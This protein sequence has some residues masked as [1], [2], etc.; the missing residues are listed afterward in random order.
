MPA[1]NESI[2][3]QHE[4]HHRDCN[5]H[6]SCLHH[7]STGNS[8]VAVRS[9]P[10]TS[11]SN[12]GNASRDSVVTF[13]DV[14]VR[15]Y[16]RSLG[17]WW[18]VEYGLSL[19]WDYTEIPAKPL[20]LDEDDANES[21]AK[22]KKNAKKAKAKVKGWFL[23][24]RNRRNSLGTI[25]PKDLEEIVQ[26]SDKARVRSRSKKKDWIKEKEKP[27][28]KRLYE[29]YKPTPKNRQELLQEFGFTEEEMN[30]AESERKLL[31]FEYSQWTCDSKNHS[32]LFL[33]RCLAF[34]NSPS[35]G[36]LPNA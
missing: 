5:N 2:S 3:K 13:G 19:G 34:T 24:N 10:E 28:V 6:K 31:R 8:S 21:V 29:D 11:A 9:R 26:I 33:Q 23:V 1:D 20:P 15:E 18:D 17:D 27:H 7:S 12:S 16:E 25:D 4:N 30:S 36:C 35:P 22:F 14:Q 32:S